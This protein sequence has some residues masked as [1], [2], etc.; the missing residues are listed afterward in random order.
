M[1]ADRNAASPSMGTLVIRADANKQIG[2]GHLMR[3][4]A[5]AQV[6]RD[7]GGTVTFACNQI[8]SAMKGRIREEG[9]IVHIPGAP[10]SQNDSQRV[11]S[12]AK[13]VEAAWVVVDGYEFGVEYQSAL[14]KAGLKVLFLDDYGHANGYCS[15]LVL[16]Y[17]A[18]AQENLYQ[19]ASGGR[20]LIGSR[21][22][23]LRREFRD[24]RAYKRQTSGQGCKLLVSLGAAIPT[25]YYRWCCTPS[26]S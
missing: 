24:W 15:D 4:L 21:Y 18:Y 17:N 1:M 16:N 26:R 2:I 10:G 22:A 9:E 6:W 20:L 3:C 12:L 14:K 11:I 25:C 13:Q 19:G 8:P 23:L 5:I 7:G